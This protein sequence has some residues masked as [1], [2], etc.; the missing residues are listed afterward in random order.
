VQIEYQLRCGPCVPAV[1]DA[2]A[3]SIQAEDDEGGHSIECSVDERNGQR[4]LSFAARYVDPVLES[5]SYSIELHQA[6]SGG[7]PGASCVVRVVEPEP[8]GIYDGRCTALTPTADEPC[9]VQVAVEG[10]VASGSIYCGGIPSRGS[11]VETR[12]LSAPGSHS[13]ATFE[14]RGC[15]G[16]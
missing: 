11:A 15:A 13:A 12:I 10:D 5:N 9:S 3:R 2:P 6:V 16:L 7:D 14:L 8:E 4:M 1:P